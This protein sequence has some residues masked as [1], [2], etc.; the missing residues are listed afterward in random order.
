[1]LIAGG[2]GSILIGAIQCVN[3]RSRHKQGI[4]DMLA[5]NG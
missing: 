2:A 4:R 3:S 1:M 5:T